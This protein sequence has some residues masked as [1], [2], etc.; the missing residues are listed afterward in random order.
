PEPVSG[1]GLHT[2]AG[3]HLDPHVWILWV[4][5]P[6]VTPREPGPARRVTQEVARIESSE[7]YDAWPGERELDPVVVFVPPTG[8]LPALTHETRLAGRDQ[9]RG[10]GEE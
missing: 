9:V 3:K 5:D 4:R 1:I 10:G 6:R 8:G 2:C 7:P